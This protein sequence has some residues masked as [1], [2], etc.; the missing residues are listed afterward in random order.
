MRRM[1]DRYA[2]VVI[3]NIKKELEKLFF[4]V[5]TPLE[6]Y[7]EYGVEEEMY[8][9]VREGSC[10]KP[11]LYVDFEYSYITDYEA[12]KYCTQTM[13]GKNYIWEYD[14]KKIFPVCCRPQINVYGTSRETISE[15]INA[16]INLY[17]VE[18]NIE[19]KHPILSNNTINLRLYME[20]NNQNEITQVD[21]TLYTSKLYFDEVVIPWFWN[22][23]DNKDVYNH[24]INLINVLIA[25]TG[26]INSCAVYLGSNISDEKEIE[27][28]KEKL[29][30]MRAN[31]NELF[32]LAN[33]PLRMQNLDELIDIRKYIQKNRMTIFEAVQ[34]KIQIEKT[35]QEEKSQK[36]VEELRKKEL[37]EKRLKEEALKRKIVQEQ[38]YEYYGESDC[39]DNYQEQKSPGFL[40]SFV[41]QK[42]EENNIKYNAGRRG[43]RDLIGQ[44][45][46][47]KT[48]GESCFNCNIRMACSR[49][50]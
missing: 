5:D 3:D 50:R 42:I 2:L 11:V 6:F 49:Y 4:N 23:L 31:R 47:A 27:R 10:V 16:V 21:A 22:K 39:Y 38:Q 34:V 17:S 35:I 46:C 43:K 48:Y 36:L 7:T 9:F 12:R 30:L 26:V 44:A 13:L 15:V 32:E 24:Q 37:Q 25:L 41:H 8:N 40:S 18:K 1:F 19:V 28:T 29:Y 20:N 45:G 33:I 14:Y